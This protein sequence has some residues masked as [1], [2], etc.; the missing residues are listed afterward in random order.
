MIGPSASVV[1]LLVDDPFFTLVAIFRGVAALK[2]ERRVLSRFR[3][4]GLK[5][6]T[7]TLFGPGV[8]GLSLS[9]QNFIILGFSVT[10]EMKYGTSGAKRNCSY[11][12]HNF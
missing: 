11:Q 9:D 4:S 6:R 8:L 1:F 3:H 10:G 12:Q 2:T 7:T 5:V